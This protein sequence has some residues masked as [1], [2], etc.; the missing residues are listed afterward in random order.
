M[1]IKNEETIQLFFADLEKDLLDCV[2]NKLK[3]LNKNPN[4]YKINFFA[5]TL[6][7]F[8]VKTQQETF[9]EGEV[10]QSVISLEKLPQELRESLSTPLEELDLSIRAV[11]CLKAAKI[12]SLIE[13]VE[14]EQEDLR[15]YKNFGQKSLSE[16]EQVLREKG[17]SFGMNLKRFA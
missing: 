13:L 4:D 1:K 10:V 16:I 6:S 11:N 8:C 14:H 3:E 17:L 5:K 15:K 7:C 12:E 2:H 9:G